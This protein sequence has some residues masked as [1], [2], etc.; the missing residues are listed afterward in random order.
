MRLLK[1]GGVVRARGRDGFKHVQGGQPLHGVILSE[2]T[3]GWWRSRKQSS[4]EPDGGD[5]EV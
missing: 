1:T 3:L 2:M 5:A 4:E